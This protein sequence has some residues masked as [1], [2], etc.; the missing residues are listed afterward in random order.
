MSEV[1]EE[2]TP[3]VCVGGDGRA[4]VPLAEHETMRQAASRIQGVLGEVICSLDRL[5]VALDAGRQAPD[6]DKLLLFRTA[7]R[8]MI[9]AFD[10]LNDDEQHELIAAG[11]AKEGA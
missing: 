5:T 1:A 8:E 7:F 10:K 2:S 3:I 4:Y 6:A 9:A 11:E